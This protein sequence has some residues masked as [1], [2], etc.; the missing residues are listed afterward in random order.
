MMPIQALQ[1]QDFKAS[2]YF[3]L[4]L[5][6]VTRSAGLFTFPDLFDQMICFFSGKQSVSWDF[7]FLNRS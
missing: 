3:C 2:L 7:I 4:P 6:L 1:S 5:L